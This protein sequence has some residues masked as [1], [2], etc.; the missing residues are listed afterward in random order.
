MSDDSSSASGTARSIGGRPY[1]RTA[2]IVGGLFI[3]GTV[4][5][6]LSVVVTAPL[7]EDP[8]Y[9]VEI[10]ENPDRMAIGALC[11]L[12]MGV[13]LALI[14]VA[15]FP[16]LKEQSEAL[17]LGY[18]VFRGGLETAMYL[19]IALS[20]L[21]LVVLGQEYVAAGAQDAPLYEV[22]GATVLADLLNPILT[23]V[24]SIGALM[25]NYLLYRSALVP[26]WIAGWGL[27]AVPFYLA[28][29]PLLMFSLI[30]PFSTVQIGLNLPMALQEMVLAVWLIVKGFDPTAVRSPTVT[31]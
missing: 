5:G 17:A 16:L 14:P 9:L 24:F 8:D 21:L 4:A 31:T 22:L 23:I 19:A 18:V 2:R 20:W 10:A 13:A 26:R 6:V 1:E 29:G 11:V 25:L 3:I 27:I 30:D 7:L 12:V 15:L 28:S